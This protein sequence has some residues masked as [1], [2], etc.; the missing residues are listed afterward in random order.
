MAALGALFITAPAQASFAPEGAPLAV[1]AAQ[2]Y[3]VL[4]ADFNRD[5]RTDAA[6]VNG[7][8]SNLSVFLRGPAGFAA[9]PGSPFPTGPGPGYGVVA[10]FNGDGFPDVATQNFS[11][12]TVSVLLRQPGGGFVAGTPLSVGSTGSVTAADFNGDGRV[13]IAAPSYNGN[14][15]ATFLGNGSGGF[16]QEGPP[17]PTGATPRDVV[18]ADFNGDGRPDL[19]VGGRLTP[20]QY[21]MP[22]RSYVLRNDGGKFTDVTEQIA[23]EL[24][25]P[26][27]MITDAQWVDFDGDHRLDLVTTGDWMPVEFY[28]NEGGHF[29]NVT[30]ATGLPPLRGWWFSLATGD[31]DGDGRPDIVAGNLGLNGPYTTSKDSPFGIYAADFMGERKTDVILTKQVDGTEY[32]YAGIAQLADAMYQLGIRFPTFGSF[33]NVSVA[34]AFGDSQLKRALHYQADTF[35]SMY[36]HND[37][38]GK[39]SAT[40]L[41]NL[42]QIAPVKAILVSDVDGDGRLDLIVAGNLYEAEPNTPRADAGNGLWLRGDG[43]GLFAAVPPYRSG[44]LA[45]GDVS[46]LTL[47]NTAKGKVIIATSADSLQAFAIGRR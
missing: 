21:P 36:F 5:G 20:H 12:G 16:T 6:T 41:P 25:H 45:P 2:P 30:Q 33:A 11:D 14:T 19:F 3:G 23:P 28:R 4:T 22:T 40:A 32:P 18:A 43:K 42:V 34:Q 38:A 46:G 31:F 8:G 37:G 47:V 7:T 27:G 35:A 9:E 29:R 26:G 15:V 24:V 1:G 44:F 10:D 39:F 17:N 13:D